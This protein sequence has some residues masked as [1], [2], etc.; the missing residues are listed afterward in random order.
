MILV[1]FM[2]VAMVVFLVVTAWSA[3]REG[4]AEDEAASGRGA[5]QAREVAKPETLEGVLVRQL[6]DAELSGPQYRRAMQRLAER[7][8]E[9]HPMTVPPEP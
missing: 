1:A 8:A 3:I 2:T 9:R 6:L 4:T 7:D 5:G